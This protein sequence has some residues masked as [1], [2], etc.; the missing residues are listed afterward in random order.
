MRTPRSR[1][2]GAPS[3]RGGPSSTT[4]AR[5]ARCR[6]P[7]L[8]VVFKAA[9]RQ[10]YLHQNLRILSAPRGETVET[11]YGLR[12][13][14]AGIRTWPPEPGE[15]TLIVFTGQPYRQFTPARFGRVVS[16]ERTEEALRVHIEL[17]SR[18]RAGDAAAWEG[19]VLAGPN[20]SEQSEIW[21]FR[22]E[23]DRP[24][25][26]PPVAYVEDGEDERAWRETVAHVAP[27]D[28]YR[29][30]VFVRVAAVRPADDTSATP[31]GPPYRLRAERAYLVRVASYNPHLDAEALGQ[32]RLVPVYDELATAVVVDASGGIPRDGA[33]DVLMAPIVG[34]PGWLE[35]NVSLGV[36]L[37]PAASLGWVAD[38]LPATA[39]PGVAEGPDEAIL[40]ALGLEPPDPIAESA[41]RAYAVVHDA[42]ADVALRLRLLRYLRDIAP[43]EARLNEAEAIALSEL[44]RH[45]D[46][47]TILTAV[48][49]DVLS[50]EGRA[51]LLA[52]ILRTGV[53]PE[54]IERVR[55]ADLSRPRGFRAVLDASAALPA[56]EQVRLTEFVVGRLLSDDRAA[57]WL[58]ELARRGF[59]R[60][61]AR[62]LEELAAKIDLDLGEEGGR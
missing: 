54:P 41:V 60:E 53:L 15:E 2:P 11:S 29:A 12:W 39:A 17:G 56:A 8:L 19:F 44:G 18:A 27:N 21:I 42:G 45:E 22:V 43:G 10:E 23:D 62:R 47:V 9:R 7:D 61:S 36:D 31:L 35:L 55:M 50:A 58:A 13:Q 57:A 28:D 20:P 4:C 30:A 5:T 52:S 1:R 34:G 59:P 51:T 25:E 3:T 49:L 16:A 26:R 32:A 37:L 46:A 40:P 48:P 14:S 24:G 38:A 6:S 33:I